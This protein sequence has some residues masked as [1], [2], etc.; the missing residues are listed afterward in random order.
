ML[1][2]LTDF[3][4]DYENS[5]SL[6]NFLT[7]MQ[8]FNEGQRLSH[9]SEIIDFFNYKWKNDRNLCLLT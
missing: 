2:I 1:L 3:D 6:E 4:K 8:M 7:I 5:E 9:E